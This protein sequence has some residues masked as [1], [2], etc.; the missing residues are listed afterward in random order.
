MWWWEQ[1]MN[2]SQHHDV[3]CCL[4]LLPLP[5]SSLF[6]PLESQ[7]FWGRRISL[8]IC[9]CKSF[10]KFMTAILAWLLQVKNRLMDRWDKKLKLWDALLN[11][12]SWNRLC[13]WNKRFIWC[14]YVWEVYFLGSASGLLLFPQLTCSCTYASECVCVCVNWLRKVGSLANWEKGG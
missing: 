10:K 14:V 12:S 2:L 6:H 4:S 1:V 8:N 9:Y 11:M 7:A 5:E 13:E 3:P